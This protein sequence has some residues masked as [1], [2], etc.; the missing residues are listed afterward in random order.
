MIL[1]WVNRWDSATLTVGSEITT[2]P[3]T[4][5][6]T[7]H[8]SRKWHT[9][10]TV[11]SSHQ[12]G[13]LGSA[14]SNSLLGVFGSNLTSTATYRVRA[15][16]ADPAAV[17]TL[18]LDTGVLAAGVKTGYGSIYKTFTPTSARYWRVD[19]ADASVPDNLQIGRIF[20]GPHW[21]HSQSMLFG[22]GVTPLDESPVEESYG[23]QSFPDARPKRRQLD[24]TLDF[25][26]E[27]EIYD[28]AFAMARAN[29]V[30]NDVLAI[31]FESGTYLSEQAVW[32]LCH[33]HKP[34]IHRLAQIYRQQF[35]VRERL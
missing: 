10:A 34:L 30:V 1:A 19:I 35:T 28:N 25:L 24:L 18:L 16:N 4:N 31:P 6:Q 22:W 11:K 13:D 17:G 26:T 12:V 14:L 7:P 2:L 8:L 15:S 27:A 5:V 33:A 23:G 20:L 9:L 3:G 32:G 21:S 29:G